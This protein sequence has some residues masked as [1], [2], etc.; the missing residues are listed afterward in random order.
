M[1]GSGQ[2]GN[3]HTSGGSIGVGSIGGAV[4]GGQP[5]GIARVVLRGT[6]KPPQYSEDGGFD[7]YG[8]QQ[9]SFLTQRDCWGIINGTIIADPNDALRQQIYEEKNTFVCDTLLRGLLQKDSK[10][11]CKYDS[12]FEMWRA[13]EAEKA[14]RAFSS[15]IR[16]RRKLY[17]STFTVDGNMEEWLEDVEDIRRQH[18]NMIEVIPDAEMVNIILQGVEETHRN[19]VR[20]FN[21]GQPGQSQVTLDVV[22]NTL[23]GEAETDRAHDTSSNG[24]ATSGIAGAAKVVWHNNSIHL[25]KQED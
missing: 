22:L 5:G 23:R 3:Q 20:L 19:V 15:V 17:T 4:A 12:G 25:W 6:N 14:K 10:K 2:Q 16:L 11:V 13:F 18:E 8:A 21:R 24:T 1:S 9:C 7:L